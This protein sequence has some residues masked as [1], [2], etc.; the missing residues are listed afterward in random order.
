MRLLFL[1]QVVNYIITSSGLDIGTLNNKIIRFSLE[2]LPLD[3]DFVCKNNRV[4]VLSDAG[5]PADVDIKLKSTAFLSIFNG[6][7]ITELLRKDKIVI[8]GDVKTAQLLVDLLNKA[9]IDLEE[10]LSKYTGDIVANGVGKT[11]NKLKAI[12]SDQSGAM[13]AIKGSLLKLFVAPSKSKR[14]KNQHI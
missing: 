13:A 14:Y 11:T 6:E 3:V 7:D 9:D 12:S 1:Q 10:E 4:F 8:K 5:T 2:D